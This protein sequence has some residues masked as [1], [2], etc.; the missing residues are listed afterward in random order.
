MND[1]TPG[2]TPEDGIVD[3]R[4]IPAYTNLWRMTRIIDGVE[5]EIG[6]WR[7]RVDY[8]VRDGERRLM[9]W[10]HSENRLD[11]TRHEHLDEMD[12][13]TL[14]PRRVQ[15]VQDD[16]TRVDLRWQGR[17]F[18]GRHWMVVPGSDEGLPLEV[19]VELPR[20]AFDWHLW[21]ILIAGFPLAE[22]YAASF[23]GRGGGSLGAMSDLLRRI[24]LRVVGRE[25]AADIDC[26]V[27]DVEA[28][29]PWR[30]WISVTRQPR[31]VVQ[32]A[33]EASPG[34]TRWWKP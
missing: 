20:P 26:F 10:Q 3:G 11:N 25:R 29:V 6:I 28:G 32:L 7:D 22:G 15:W 9:R 23:L 4:I 17:C 2:I 1:I 19:S 34:I 30:F 21:G 24:T 8:E 27:V 18:A 14:A 13:V 5:E 16:V 31:P 33:I 12:A